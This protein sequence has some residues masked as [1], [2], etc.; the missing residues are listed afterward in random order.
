MESFEKLINQIGQLLE[1]LQNLSKPP[2]IA[3]TLFFSPDIPIIP[4]KSYLY[5]IAKF[6]PC[7]HECF[8]VAIEFVRRI[9]EMN[10][11]LKVNQQNIHRFFFAS[12]L[13]ST[14]F[15]DDKFYDN[16]YYSQVA[17]LSVGEV[18][19]L[20]LEFL[21]LIDFSLR[22]DQDDYNKVLYSLQTQDFSI[23]IQNKPNQMEELQ[24][25]IN[26]IPKNLVSF[27]LQSTNEEE[28][29]TPNQVINN[30]QTQ[31]EHLLKLQMLYQQQ[32]L[33]QKQILKQ[34][35]IIQE[36]RLHE[37]ETVQEQLQ[38]QLLQQQQQ[39]IQ[40]QL[41]LEQQQ[42]QQQE[43]E[44]E[45]EQE[46]QLQFQQLQLQQQQQQQ[47][48]QNYQENNVNQQIEN[49]EYDLPEISNLIF[50]S[51]D[52]ENEIDFEENEKQNYH[53][54]NSGNLF[55][56]VK[57]ENPYNFFVKNENHLE[58]FHHNENDFETEKDSILIQNENYF[59]K[60]TERE[61]V[62]EQEQEQ[63]LEQ[64]QDESYFEKELEEKNEEEDDYFI[65]IEE[66]ENDV[67]YPEFLQNF[68]DFEDQENDFDEIIKSN[69]S[70]NEYF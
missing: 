67:S 57:N 70:D 40:K 22:F 36:Q 59:E 69:S 7:S 11:S 52:F 42:Q 62:Q 34:K 16:N 32:Q 24:N 21:F 28:I 66:N 5:R 19:A 25:K 35:Q 37:S 49:Y 58:Q 15:C 55:E 50:D 48:Q 27:P 68:S 45:Q 61:T 31:N 23:L 8:V 17:G 9:L 43:Q 13:V 2:Y 65:Y 14:K 46:L 26:T 64:E 12:I 39:Q 1:F 18:N 33:L 44:Q 3:Q 53:Q 60:K 63:E 30:N 6:S 47:Q 41:Q 20:E 56:Y 4:I 51:D 29:T 54:P 10:T 38:F